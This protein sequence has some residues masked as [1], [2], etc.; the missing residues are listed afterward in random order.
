MI[1]SLVGACDLRI[2]SQHFKIWL[3]KTQAA[4]AASV[5]WGSS[6]VVA[7]AVHLRTSWERG[8]WNTG[9]KFEERNVN[10][11]VSKLDLFKGDNILKFHMWFA[12]LIVYFFLHECIRPIYFCLGMVKRHISFI[13]HF[14]LN[15]MRSSN[16]QFAP[17]TVKLI[18][19]FYIFPFL[20]QCSSRAVQGPSIYPLHWTSITT[21]IVWCISLGSFFVKTW[22]IP[23][24]TRFQ[25]LNSC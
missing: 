19:A 2:N 18:C 3:K 22:N 24:N 10:F 9:K 15:N 20:V 5:G 21:L 14:F 17:N 7:R 23:K 8:F 6:S 13:V 1:S 4:S 12:W 16:V 11:N 25:L